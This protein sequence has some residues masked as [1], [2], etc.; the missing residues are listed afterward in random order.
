MKNIRQQF[1]G[2]RLILSATAAALV[3]TFA[4]AGVVSFHGG[5][6]TPNPA[7]AKNIRGK[8]LALH[9]ELPAAQ[10]DLALLLGFCEQRVVEF[11]QEG[12]AFERVF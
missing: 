4:I 3:V 5:L 9:G 7:D 2:L 11:A 12:G 10:Q 6:G 8:V 1:T